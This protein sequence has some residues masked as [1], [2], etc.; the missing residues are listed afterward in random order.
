MSDNKMICRVC[1]KEYEACH[2]TRN[3]GTFRWQDVA[4]CVDHGMEYLE[5]IR[6]SRAPKID[7]VTSPTKK[8][9]NE[10]TLIMELEESTMNEL[11]DVLTVEVD[12]TETTEEIIDE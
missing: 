11:T 9:V 10:D 12:E 6:K 1:G 3:N 7:R 2:T 5:R 8:P 4:C